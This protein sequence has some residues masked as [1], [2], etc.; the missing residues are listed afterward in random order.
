MRGLRVTR[1]VD[2]CEHVPLQPRQLTRGKESA[3]AAM[4]LL[5]TGVDTTVIALW[6][7]HEQIVTTNIYLHADMTLKEAAIAKVTHPTSP[8][9]GA[10]SPPTPSWRYLPRCDYADLFAPPTARILSSETDI[11]IITTSA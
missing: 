10:T 7:G 4:R 2:A 1:A 9:R 3:A 8:P 5:H 6:L 11:G